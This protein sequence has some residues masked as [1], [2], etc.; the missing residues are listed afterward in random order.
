MFII[1]CQLFKNGHCKS[2]SD[3]EK[4]EYCN[5]EARD[6]NEHKCAKEVAANDLCKN[7]EMCED[8]MVCLGGKYG[9]Y[10]WSAQMG[11]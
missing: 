10:V 7:S 11:I 6:S 1:S 5:T 2:K 9:L 4:G 3:C 8:G